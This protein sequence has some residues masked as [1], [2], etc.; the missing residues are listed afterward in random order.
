MHFA[1]R[2]HAEPPRDLLQLFGV[3]VLAGVLVLSIIADRIAAFERD[4]AANA[5]SAGEDRV[6]RTGDDLWSDR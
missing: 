1:L 4:E 6:S 3:G 5:G 2:R